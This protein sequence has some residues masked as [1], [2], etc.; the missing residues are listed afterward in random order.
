LERGTAFTQSSRR[1]S[2]D[3]QFHKETKPA[4]ATTIYGGKITTYRKLACEVINQLTPHFPGLPSSNTNNHPLPGAN[5]DT[6]T[7]DVYND[8]AQKNYSWL[9]QDLLKRYLETYGT[10]TELVLKHCTSTDHLGMHF[11]HQLYQKEVDYLIKEEWATNS[12]DI[13]W[14]RTKLGLQFNTDEIKVL[15]H[16]INSE[17]Q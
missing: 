17:F 9:E 4:P 14:R 2:R 12:D 11:G 1:L 3:Y 8:Y 5:L 13:L 7:F 16:Y 15:E 10:R 6:M